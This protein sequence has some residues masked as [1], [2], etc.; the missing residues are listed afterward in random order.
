MEIKEIIKALECCT[1]ETEDADCSICPYNDE[2]FCNLNALK[3]ALDLINR[4]QK[5]KSALVEHLK[6]ARRQLKTAK[7][8]ARKEFAERLKEKQEYYETS[9]GY[10]SFIV[11]VKDID[12]LLKEMGVEL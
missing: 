1:G 10:Q 11:D 12:N 4:Q 2:G 8:E 6:K 7:S 5:D 9:E 3:E